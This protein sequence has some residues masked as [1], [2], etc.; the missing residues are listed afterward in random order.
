MSGP[1]FFPPLQFLRPG[2]IGE[3]VANFSEIQKRTPKR[4]ALK[5]SITLVLW[6]G[7][8]WAD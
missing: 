3:V 7:R 6:F 8:I 5:G 2:I 1:D 4:Q